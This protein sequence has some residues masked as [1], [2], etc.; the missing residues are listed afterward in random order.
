VSPLAEAGPSQ[1][2]FLANRKYV[3]QV[4]GSHAG[5]LVLGAKDLSLRG[6]KAALVSENPYRD[7]ARVTAHWF[8]KPSLPALGVH[9]TAVVDP[10][11]R[12]APTARVGA[13]VV[14]E[15]GAVVGEDCALFPFSYVG[16][17]VSLGRGCRLYPGA[18]VLER[19][20]L[21]E[22]VILQSGVVIGGDGF[23]FAPDFPKGYVKVPQVGSVVLEDDVEVQANACVDRG[24]LGPTRL[25][26]GTKV[27]N[28]VQIAHNVVV[29]QNTVFASQ[30]GISG[31]T[32]IGNWVTFAGQSAIA[33]HLSVGDG[34]VITGQAGA[35][36]DVPAK[37][38]VSGSPA[39]P[40]LAHHRGLAEL[41]KLPELKQRIKALEARLA[42]LEAGRAS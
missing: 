24:A 35:G 12:V 7:F 39:Q 26:K 27:D 31:S 42:A 36:K 14:V 3:P 28:L 11:A 32:H 21:G 29:G 40:T 16:Y 23:G 4:A 15:A 17:G 6:G 13:Y 22:R 33:G 37:A 34:A 1:L 18:V 19:C 9:A 38:M 41:Q 8:D 5:A 30:A 10:A 25:G 20:Q 2:S